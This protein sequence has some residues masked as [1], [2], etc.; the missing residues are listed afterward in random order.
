MI[1]NNFKLTA[2]DRVFGSRTSLRKHDKNR[3]I[4]SYETVPDAVKR[5]VEN[6]KQIEKGVKKPKDHIGNLSSY[7]IDPSLLTLAS[8]WTEDTNVSWQ[9][10]GRQFVRNKNGKIPSNCGQV[11]EAYLY[12]REEHS[13]FQFV[14]KNKKIE[15]ALRCRRKKKR[16]FEDIS[17]PEDASA[18]EVSVLLEDS[19]KKGLIDIG[20]NVVESTILKRRFDKISGQTVIETVRIHVR[21]HP[22]KKLRVKLFNKH[23]HYMRLNPDSYFENLTREEV[24]H[25][26]EFIGETFDP[27][28]NILDLRTKLKI[29]ERTRHLQIWH[30]GSSIS[31]HGH[32]L[33]C[34][35]IIYDPAVF[36]TS[37]EYEKKFNFKVDIQKIIEA[38]ELY[39]IGRCAN[40]DEQLAYI[41]TRF[42][43]LEDLQNGLQLDEDHDNIIL[44]DKMRFFHGDGP[45]AAFEAGNKKGGHYFCPTCDINIC[46]TDDIVHT[47][48]QKYVSLKDRQN[49]VL[50]GEFGK[51]NS[52]KR[53]M[54]PFK[55]LSAIQLKA[56]LLSR[57]ID[58]SDLK[59]TKKALL[60][61]LKKKLRGAKRVPVILFNNP[62][63][64]FTTINSDSYEIAMVECMHDIAN[65]I[66]NIFEELPHHIKKAEYKL[67]L[68]QLLDIL[69]SEK[70]IK[71]CCD[72][73][74]ML[75]D[76]TF[77]LSKS[78]NMDGLTLRLLQT[79]CEIQRILYL[80]DEMRSPKEILRLHNTCFEHFCLIKKIMPP[81]SICS[82]NISRDKMFGKY[83]HNLL[84]HAPLQYRLISGSS[85]NCE[86]EERIFNSLKSITKTCSNNKPGQVIGTMI[87]H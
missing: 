40:S 51:T 43:C 12:D 15:K 62:L 5:T 3:L 17:I 13:S 57:N 74:K 66:G 30:D 63:Q 33:F 56:E 79:L 55:K 35:N 72:K 70:E 38:P 77:H 48:Q 50:Q 53:L 73:R 36:Y 26:L 31:N 71:R 60:P 67:A 68:T 54:E 82:K 41:G 14:F 23:E 44:D 87:S 9:P 52:L 29:H 4:C 58:I 1:E 21:K 2:V 39:I 46:L 76:I 20:E 75:L 28:D 7:A 42:S 18:K 69:R 6:K 32:I 24:E 19:I 22:L 49:L 61:V 86:D 78:N 45:A 81:D 59:T 37:D 25:R 84:V 34:V 85:I 16:F 64:K 47:Y 10:L 80:G 8:H 27:F 11:V 65:H 83:K